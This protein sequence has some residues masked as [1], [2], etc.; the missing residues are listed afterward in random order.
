MS[1]GG[2]VFFKRWAGTRGRSS[3][4]KCVSDRAKRSCQ[5][6]RKT[7]KARGRSEE[8]KKNQVT[9]WTRS[10]RRDTEREE[11]GSGNEG[12]FECVR[13]TWTEAIVG[14]WS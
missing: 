7:E 10:A 11:E 4:A 8:E 1:E 2:K 3:K 12:E 13:Q 6:E 9:G 14:S 5:R